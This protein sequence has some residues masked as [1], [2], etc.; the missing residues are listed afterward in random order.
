MATPASKIPPSIHCSS[1]WHLQDNPRAATIYN[2]ALRLSNGG[3]AAFY[4]S[5]TSRRI[6]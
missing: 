4:L 3:E 5:A 6:L 1:E 2:L